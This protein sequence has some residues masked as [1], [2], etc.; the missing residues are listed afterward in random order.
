MAD[1][2]GLY[3]RDMCLERQPNVNVNELTTFVQTGWTHQRVDGGPDMRYSHNPP[4]GYNRVTGYQLQVNGRAFSYAFDPRP[5]MRS[6]EIW[7]QFYFQKLRPRAIQIQQQR[8]TIDFSRIADDVVR[9]NCGKSV[10]FRD[11]DFSVAVGT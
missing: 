9:C 6:I 1:F 11:G 8:A 7:S 2:N 5:I 10:T 4:I 3:F